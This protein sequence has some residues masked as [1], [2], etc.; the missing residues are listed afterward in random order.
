[1]MMMI[2]ITSPKDC[3][4]PSSLSLLSSPADAISAGLFF[5]F[6]M[7]RMRMRMRVRARGSMSRRAVDADDV[8]DVAFFPEEVGLDQWAN[9]KSSKVW[10][11][12]CYSVVIWNYSI[13]EVS[14]APSSSALPPSPPRA[15]PPLQGRRKIWAEPGGEF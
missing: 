1:M 13:L 9:R 15:P 10:C 12:Y 4:F 14:R 6:W 7:V 11:Y 2:I 8:G 5:L 3:W